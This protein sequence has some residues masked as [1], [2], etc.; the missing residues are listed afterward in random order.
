VRLRRR[1]A[2]DQHQAAGRVPKTIR[3]TEGA[4]PHRDVGRPWRRA[5]TARTL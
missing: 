4:G 3:R 1:G 2:D 5:V